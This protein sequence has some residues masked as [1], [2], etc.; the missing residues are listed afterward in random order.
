MTLT[1]KV[2]G[3]AV[4]AFAIAVFCCRSEPTSPLLNPVSRDLRKR[5][6]MP[7]SI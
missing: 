2:A 5:R 7:A 4:F 6:G 1:Q 3:S